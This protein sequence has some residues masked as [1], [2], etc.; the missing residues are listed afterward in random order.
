M[1]RSSSVILYLSLSCIFHVSAGAAPYGK[2]TDIEGHRYELPGKGL[3][4]DNG[5]CII[6]NDEHEKCQYD[7][8]MPYVPRHEVRQSRTKPD[9]TWCKIT[10]W[11]GNPGSRGATAVESSGSCRSGKCMYN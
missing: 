5:G 3:R 8:F 11:Y 10:T 9:W 6:V 1:K 7:C 2:C 4:T